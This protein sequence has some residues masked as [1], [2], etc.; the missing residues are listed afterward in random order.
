MDKEFWLALEKNDYKIPD[1]YEIGELTKTL[2]GYLGNLD[3]ELR[4]EIAYI[5]YANWL[6]RDRYSRDEIRLHI[7]ELLANLEIRIGETQSDSVFLRTFSILLL[8]EIVHNDNKKSLLEETDIRAILAKGLWYLDA[9]KDPRGHI[10]VQGWAHAL[11][12]TADL[13]MVLGKNRHMKKDD[14][15]KILQGMADKLVHSTTW[16]YIHGEDERLANAVTTILQRNLLTEDFL[17]AWFKSLTEPEPAWNDAYVD[18]GKA[19]AFHNTR[20]FLRSL[21]ESIRRMDAF[22]EKG[23]VSQFTYDALDNLKPY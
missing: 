10:P 5:V 19:K 22:P 9:E 14:L 7:E 17:K 23:T 20:N 2:F 13:M 3:P 21:S 8:A 15:E 6:K 18:E 16:V 1:G 4:D 11:A 12:H